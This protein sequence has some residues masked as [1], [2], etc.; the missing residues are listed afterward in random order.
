M[1][2]YTHTQ[3]C[4][5]HTNIHT[6][7][8]IHTVSTDL[9]YENIKFINMWRSVFELI[10][11]ERTLIFNTFEHR[12]GRMEIIWPEVIFLGGNIALYCHVNRG[13]EYV[14]WPAEKWYCSVTVVT[15]YGL[16][17]RGLGPCRGRNFSLR[18]HVQTGSGVHPA[19]HLMGTEDEAAGEWRSVEVKNT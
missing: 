8:H 2:K 17:D 13:P 9:C 7:I 4:T 16:D 5:R 3:T 19:S 15:G 18:H 6:Q 10:V 11:L 14:S 12:T 1:N